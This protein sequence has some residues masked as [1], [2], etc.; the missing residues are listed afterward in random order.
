MGTLR[1]VIVAIKGAV[2]GG[3]VLEKMLDA[4]LDGSDRAEC[5]VAGDAMAKGFPMSGVLLI[6][7]GKGDVCPLLHVIPRTGTAWDALEG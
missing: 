2:R 1:G 5:G 7:V 3:I 6:S 4:A